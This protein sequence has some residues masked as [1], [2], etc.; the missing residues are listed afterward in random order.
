MLKNF[1]APKALERPILAELAIDPLFREFITLKPYDKRLSRFGKGIYK[2]EHDGFL[3]RPNT[4][5][6]ERNH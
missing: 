2:I 6:G 3:V 4:F 1:L 5:A